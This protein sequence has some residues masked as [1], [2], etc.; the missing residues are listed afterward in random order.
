MKLA[1][2]KLRYFQLLLI[3]AVLI[4]LFLIPFLFHPDLKTQYFHAQFLAHG[5]F[6]IYQYIAQNIDQLG[7]KD[8]FNYPPLTY[9]LLG[10]WHVAI[11]PFVGEGF[12]IW[13]NDW[14]ATRFTADGMYRFLFY[15]KLPYL[16]ADLATGLVLMQFVPNQYKKRLAILWFY[17][18]ITLYIIYGL[19][20][21]DIIPTLFSVLSLLF[22]MKQSYA[23][24]GLWLGLAIALKIYPLLFLPFYL[25]PLSVQRRFREALLVGGTSLGVFLLS[26]LPVWHDFLSIGNSGLLTKIF[27]IRLGE[28]PVFIP[29]YGLLFLLALLRPLTWQRLNF[30]IV[31][32]L[33]LVYSLTLIHPQWLLWILPFL[34]LLLVENNWLL[35]LFIPLLISYLLTIISLEDRF[36]TLGIFS[37]LVPS[38]YDVG[39]FEQTIFSHISKE[40]VVILSQVLGIST[41]AS[42]VTI[43]FKMLIYEK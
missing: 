27:E 19:A 30:Y 25:G 13:L 33:A 18:P 4:R 7:Y 37:P 15:A 42:I 6:N 22:F 10:I 38:I 5:V 39:F 43:Y 14:S 31:A 41:Y 3:G 2:N 32:V 40:A 35:F 12:S 24:S 34:L 17:N 23:R 8:T 20:N 21:F 29:L 9:W 1:T 36:L 28:I 16:I 11:S 26:I